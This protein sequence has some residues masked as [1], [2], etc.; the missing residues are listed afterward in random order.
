MATSLFDNWHRTFCQ[1]H[2][3]MK[4]TAK[5]IVRALIG[6]LPIRTRLA[7]VPL[8]STDDRISAFLTDEPCE[9]LTL[10]TM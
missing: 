7:L 5:N 3:Q 10:A 6:W 4:Q 8:L 2:T 1:N 9:H